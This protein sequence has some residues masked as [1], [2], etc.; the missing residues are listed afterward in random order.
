VLSEGRVEAGGIAF[1]VVQGTRPLA[2]CLHGFPDSAWTWWHLLP[3]LDAGFRAV[4]PFMRGYA[5][6]EIAPDGDYRVAALAQDA[7]ALHETL[8]GDEDAVL[9]GH[10]WGAEAAY[11]AAALAPRN[12]RRLVTIG[13]PPLA[14]D[15]RLFAD[16][17]QRERFAYLFLLKTPDAQDVVAADDMSRDWTRSGTRCWCATPRTISPQA[18]G[19]RSWRAPGTS[20]TSSGRSP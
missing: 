18:R 12:W 13:V 14:L 19:W 1:G 16:P 2:L 6:T 4:A 20:C 11:T 5:P 17:A 9:I 8:G 3:A 15:E 7:N 10:D